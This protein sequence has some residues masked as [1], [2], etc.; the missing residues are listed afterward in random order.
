[1]K[2]SGPADAS[3]DAG[4]LARLCF[5]HAPRWFSPPSWS[6]VQPHG[7]SAPATSVKK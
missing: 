7:S 1:M 5:I 2:K 4:A 3:I 6:A